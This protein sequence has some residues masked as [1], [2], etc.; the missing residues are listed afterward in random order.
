MHKPIEIHIWGFF[1]LVK[2]KHITKTTVVFL[3][4]QNKMKERCLGFI[5]CHFLFPFF[6]ILFPLLASSTYA[7]EKNKTTPY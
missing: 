6:S 7:H 2:Q 3:N 5:E 1:S 4:T